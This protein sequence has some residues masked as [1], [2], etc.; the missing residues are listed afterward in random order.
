MQRQINSKYSVALCDALFSIKDFQ[1]AFQP[2]KPQQIGNIRPCH[3]LLQN[4]ISHLLQVADHSSHLTPS[5]DDVYNNE[6]C[7]KFHQMLCALLCGFQDSLA[8]LA[9]DLSH[10]V[11]VQQDLKSPLVKEASPSQEVLESL[12]REIHF[13]GLCL[14]IITYSSVI[15]LHLST[16]ANLLEQ[17]ALNNHV[18]SWSEEENIVDNSSS[19]FRLFT[20]PLHARKISTYSKVVHKKVVPD[21][22]IF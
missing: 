13:Y 11:A 8:K 3:P 17:Y 5:L 12:V 21:G 6:R 2:K 20:P 19:N 16:I 7:T 18:D 1:V 15:H 9:G 14:H 10:N 22:L 4:V